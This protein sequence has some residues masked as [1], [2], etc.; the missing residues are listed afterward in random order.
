M[1]LPKWQAFLVE[2]S[3]LFR[4]ER[5]LWCNR[6]VRQNKLTD[7]LA[8][9]RIGGINLDCRTMEECARG[10]AVREKVESM[11]RGIKDEND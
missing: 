11:G 9:V 3:E 4:N 1:V 7:C 10:Y 8:I 2:Y 5:P 6:I